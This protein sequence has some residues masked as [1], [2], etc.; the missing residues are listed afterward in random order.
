[1]L[2]RLEL[3]LPQRTGNPAKDYDE[4]KKT[5]ESWERRLNAPGALFENGSTTPTPTSGT[6]SFTSVSA[7][8]NYTKADTRVLID[9]AVTITTNGT[10]ATNIIV[11]LPFTPATR[12]SLSGWNFTTS[13]S[14]GGYFNTDGNAYIARYDGAYSGANGNVLHVE[15]SY[16]V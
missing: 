11:P 13:V 2:T 14:L 9:I 10:A 12:T 1:M 3:K 5:L 4:L 15:G 16:K 6:G 7:A 8:V